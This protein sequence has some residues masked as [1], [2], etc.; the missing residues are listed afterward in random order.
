MTLAAGDYYPDAKIELM[1]SGST[2]AIAKG[3]LLK[4]DPTGD[5]WLACS[6]T[7]TEYGP[8]AVCVEAMAT[9]GTQVKVATRGLVAVTG[10]GVIEPNDML[11]ASNSTAT[12]VAVYA[13]RTI[14]VTT[15]ST[16]HRRPVGRMVSSSED[17]G[18]GIIA[19]DSAAADV[20]IIELF[21]GV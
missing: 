8:F 7:T 5:G 17:E 13:A 21:G 15:A 9:G 20:V 2:V 4:W 18:D 14:N 16:E 11:Q 10:A 12:R 6:A 19:T 3:A 1:K